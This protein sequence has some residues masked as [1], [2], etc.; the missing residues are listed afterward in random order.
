[1]YKRDQAGFT[2][3]EL[4]LVMA[5]TSM[6]LLIAFAGQRGLRSRAMFDGSVDKIV[7]SIA[8]AR[9]EAAAGVNLKGT[10]DGTNNTGCGG[11][12]GQQWE[13]AGVAWSA[14]DAGGSNTIKMDYYKVL[15]GSNSCI[16]DT[17]SVSLQSLPVTV[18]I[19]TPIPLAGVG[20]VLYVRTSTGG[21]MVCPVTSALTDV[22]G[23]FTAGSCAPG[24]IS[25]T[26]SDQDGHVSR[27]DVD[28]SGLA[29]RVN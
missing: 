10:G 2:L 22:P 18:K 14:T 5:I 24:T 15:P 1:M 6:M 4:I 19:G 12:G 7:A 11:G 16:F 23:V 17:R 8:Q 28:S 21:L 13:F 26:F 25:F 3:I 29:K 20:R 27:V 9:T